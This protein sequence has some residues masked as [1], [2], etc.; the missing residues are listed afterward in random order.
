[1]H[2][3]FYLSLNEENRSLHPLNST[4]P[5]A[6]KNI[7]PAAQPSS[8]ADQQAKSPSKLLCEQALG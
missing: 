8:S 6:V 7:L 3:T 4:L 1:M 2:K 5:A